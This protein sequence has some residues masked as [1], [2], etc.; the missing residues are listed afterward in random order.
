MHRLQSKI[1]V[2]TGAARGIGHA[3]ATRFHE[4]GGSVVLTD[5]DR[6]AGQAAA[7]AIGCRF[8]ALDVREEGDWCATCPRPM[9]WSTMP[10]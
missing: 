9:W 8:I 5:I 7:D 3:I 10:G 1:C 2:V 4:E 6:R